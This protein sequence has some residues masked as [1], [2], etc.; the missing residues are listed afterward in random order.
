MCVRAMLAYFSECEGDA[1]WARRG[2]TRVGAGNVE[3]SMD[4]SR[5]CDPRNARKS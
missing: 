1:I 2:W 3:A 5:D 4:M